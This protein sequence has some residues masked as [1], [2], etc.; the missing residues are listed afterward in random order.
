MDAEGLITPDKAAELT[1][2]SPAAVRRL[3]KVPLVRREF[4]GVVRLGVN[5]REVLKTAT[6]SNARGKLAK[7]LAALNGTEHVGRPPALSTAE[8]AVVVDRRAAGRG[9]RTIA[10]ELNA[11]R[12]LAEPV[13]HMAVKRAHERATAAV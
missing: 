12:P 6:D 4:G 8:V 2:W 3:G 7:L 1:S 11:A 5:A 9:W 10:D 13:S